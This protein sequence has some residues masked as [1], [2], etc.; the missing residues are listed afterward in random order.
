MSIDSQKNSHQKNTP[1]AL[2]HLDSNG[3]IAMVDVSGKTATT[4]EATAVGQVRF[5]VRFISK[6]KPL[7]V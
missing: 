1:S 3:D 4:R 5:L 2:S 6:L 7:M